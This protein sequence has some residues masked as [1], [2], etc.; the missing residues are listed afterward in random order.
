M[1]ELANKFY[2]FLKTNG[3]FKESLHFDPEVEWLIKDRENYQVHSNFR[4]LSFLNPPYK[5]FFDLCKRN[6]PFGT[7]EK[8]VTVMPYNLLTNIALAQHEALKRVF[9]LA[10]DFE[11]IDSKLNDNS[12]YG[13]I[14]SKLEN[15]GLQKDIV[16]A[17]DNKLRNIVAHGDWYVQ[18]RQFTYI[19]D[20]KKSIS[21]KKLSQRV[22]DFIRFSN[23][24]YDVY[25]SNHLP[26][27]ALEFSKQ[28]MK[29]DAID[30]SWKLYKHNRG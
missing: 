25:W 26:P 6:D 9:R 1:E 23:A 14:I 16:A 18:D 3:Y 2:G 15:K 11:K 29:E 5:M 7:F 10:L 13:T 8:E 21:Y 12:T 27:E 28:K 24:F 30:L 4:I 19:D 22:N 20:V 17:L